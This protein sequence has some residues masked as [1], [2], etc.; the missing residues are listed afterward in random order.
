M[1]DK[2]LDR[3]REKKR[4]ELQLSMEHKNLPKVV[5]VSQVTFSRF[6]ENNKFAVLDFWAEW[7]G[8]CRMVGPVIEELAHE[9]G[10]LV[11]FGKCNTDLNPRLAGRYGI[12][13]IPTVLLFSNG[14]MVDRVIGAYPKEAFKSR[15]TNAFGIE[16]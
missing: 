15:I 2:E 12:S 11:T 1:D 13:A 3:I 8:P 5:E 10:G 4:R 14:Q 9:F 7:C 16:G 6:V